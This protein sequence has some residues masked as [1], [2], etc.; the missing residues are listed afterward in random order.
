MALQS[1]TALSTITLQ[2]EANEVT[3]SGIPSSYRDLILVA[4]VKITATA[5][6]C[7][8][9][10]RFNGDSGSSY[11]W[12]QAFGTGSG[13]V[14]NTGTFTAMPFTPNYYVSTTN[15]EPLIFQVMDY[16]TTDKHKATL[17]RYSQSD[18]HVN[19]IAGR[20]ASTAAITSVSAIMLVTNFAAGSTFSLY[21][22]T[23]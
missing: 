15:Y 22:R 7:E 20:W 16:V 19:M 1:I 3:F 23:A 18:Q 9:R 4:N 14:S 8:P 21:G 11:P 2:A 12:V 17:S 6:G 13:T 10:I 5:A